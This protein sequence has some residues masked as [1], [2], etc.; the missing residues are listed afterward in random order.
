MKNSSV[1]HVKEKTR[2]GGYVKKSFQRTIH[3]LVEE[4]CSVHNC[5]WG[6][7][8]KAK[9]SYLISI[10]LNYQQSLKDAESHS[11]LRDEHLQLKVN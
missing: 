5:K 8:V 3:P 7:I 4:V 10:S 9:S 6:L 1:K 11:F 2:K